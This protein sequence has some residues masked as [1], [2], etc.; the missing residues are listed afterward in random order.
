MS[1]SPATISY[2]YF[3]QAGLLS[4]TCLLHAILLIFQ[5][6]VMLKVKARQCV[7]VCVCVCVCTQSCPTLCNLM[8]C[9]PPGSSV[10]GIFQARNTGVGCYFLLQGI[11]PTQGLNPSLL[12]LLHWQ[13]DSLPLEPLGKPLK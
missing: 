4:A 9:S 12:C 3:S 1:V 11:F 8:D 2:I 6:D 7:C 10:H 5:K 13:V